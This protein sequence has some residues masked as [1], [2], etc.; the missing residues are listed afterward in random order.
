MVNLRSWLVLGITCI[1]GIARADAPSIEGRIAIGVRTSSTSESNHDPIYDD[2]SSVRVAAEGLVGVRFGRAV[3]G[4]HG[5]IATPLRFS[6]S[7]QY[8][9]GEVVAE[10]TSAIYPLD[11]GLGVQV[12]VGGGFWVSAWVGATLAFAHASSAA[13]HISAIDFTGDIPATSWSYQTTSLGFGAAVG[14]D[15][16]RTESGRF[17]G[18]VGL[19]RQG[20]GPI[21]IRSNAGG[22]GTDPDSLSTTSITL[23]VA[24]AY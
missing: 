23:G 8:D 7:P 11:L 6:S 4:L 3:V 21:P 14:Y 12:D 22:T 18:V 19:D 24:Y 5:G 17:S 16:V 10:T 20:I 1:A 15:I 13:Q 9:S 2:T